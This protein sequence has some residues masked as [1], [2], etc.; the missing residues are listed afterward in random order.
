MESSKLKII[1]SR[2]DL[3]DENNELLL[4]QEQIGLLSTCA[5]NR[6]TGS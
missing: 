4:G 2:R 5:L 1:I 3:C 6:G